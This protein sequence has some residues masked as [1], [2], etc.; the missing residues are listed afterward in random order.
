MSSLENINESSIDDENPWK[1][2]KASEIILAIEIVKE[3]SST[4]SKFATV[5]LNSIS[6][7]DKKSLLTLSDNTVPYGWRKL[8]HGPKLATEFMKSVAVR[9]QTVASYLNQLDEAVLEVDFSKIFNV[10]SFLSTM[11]L[12]SSRELKVSTSNL[13][14]DSFTS[15]SEFEKIKSARR[16]AVQV[17]PL[18]IDGL[19]FEDN[20]LVQQ[21]GSNTGRFH[22]SKIFL[23]FN[24]STSVL[25]TGIHAVPLYATHSREKFLCNIKLC[26]SLDTDAITLSGVSLIVPGN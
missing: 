4:L 22:T 20:R 26:T 9:V 1:L 8:W 12:V 11:K 23:V 19:A 14:L 25:N 2:F 15:Q 21:S 7:A 18:V 6:E 13:S 5:D 24:A 17:A 3:I 16:V 10:D